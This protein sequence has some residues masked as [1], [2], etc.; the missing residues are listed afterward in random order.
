MDCCFSFWSTFCEQFDA[1]PIYGLYN[2]GSKCDAELLIDNPVYYNWT[3]STI[4]KNIEAVPNSR[5]SNDLFE[6]LKSIKILKSEMEKELISKR[7]DFHINALNLLPELKKITQLRLSELKLEETKKK[8]ISLHKFTDVNEILRELKCTRKGLSRFE[9]ELRSQN[10][11]INIHFEK[12]RKVQENK[13]A[14]GDLFLKAKDAMNPKHNEQSSIIT[15]STSVDVNAETKEKVVWNTEKIQILEPSIYINKVEELVKIIDK[16]RSEE[17]RCQKES[18]ELWN[19]QN[20]LYTNQKKLQENISEAY[21]FVNKLSQKLDELTPFKKPI[22]D[23][24]GFNLNG[25]EF[26]VVKLDDSYEEV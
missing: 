10:E 26:S 13:K 25:I 16:I 2:T 9:N 24:Q 19:A 23:D 22:L 18:L 5:S 3:V 4:N 6:V 1:R 11:K 8:V 12:E 20:V 7:N 14:L 15:Q 21:E 17:T